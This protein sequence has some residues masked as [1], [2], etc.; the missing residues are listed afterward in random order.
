M[1]SRVRYLLTNSMNKEICCTQYRTWDMFNP[2]LSWN[3][4]I[5]M[6]MM[7]VLVL[8]ANSQDCHDVLWPTVQSA[9]RRKPA[10]IC[11][12]RIV[13]SQIEASHPGFLHVLQKDIDYN[14]WFAQLDIGRKTIL[15]TL[16]HTILNVMSS[17]VYPN[18]VVIWR[19]CWNWIRNFHP[20]S[21]SGLCNL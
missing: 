20:G 9:W 2:M 15:A 13:S 8:F 12:G 1:N 17:V 14:Q 4:L 11:T 21:G 7:E 6:S 19:L 16:V 18:S 5:M 10:P 3:V